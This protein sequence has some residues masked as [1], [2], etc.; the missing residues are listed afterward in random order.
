MN[1]P[2]KRAFIEIITLIARE[3][4]RKKLKSARNKRYYQKHKDEILQKSKIKN[5]LYKKFIQTY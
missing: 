3:Q 5:Q 4:H 1:S 2:Q